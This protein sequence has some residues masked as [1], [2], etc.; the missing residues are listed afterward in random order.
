VSGGIGGGEVDVSEHVLG[1]KLGYTAVAR[2]WLKKMQPPHFTRE[3]MDSH[4][5][6]GTI[7]EALFLSNSSPMTNFLAA[8]AHVMT[9]R[10][11]FSLFGTSENV[12]QWCRFSSAVSKVNC[13][14]SGSSYTLHNEFEC[15]DSRMSSTNSVL[16]AEIGETGGITW[17]LSR[18]VRKWGNVDV[19]IR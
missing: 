5:S 10:R 12:S 8:R 11:M 17:R 14:S 19:S 15:R 13:Y 7:T 1:V 6:G 18:S 3:K 16:D 2:H 4:A 9:V